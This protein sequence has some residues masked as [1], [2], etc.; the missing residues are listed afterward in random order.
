MS[1]TKINKK[2]KET[3]K[4][5]SLRTDKNNI[6]ISIVNNTQKA[7]RSGGAAN[8][9]KGADKRFRD[10][11]DPRPLIQQ[12]FNGF[13]GVPQTITNEEPSEMRRFT[14]NQGIRANLREA[15][16]PSSGQFI[17]G[18]QTV[19]TGTQTRGAFLQRTGTQTRRRPSRISFTNLPPLRQ[20]I[21]TQTDDRQFIPQPS[22][23]SV[24]YAAALLNEE[25]DRRERERMAAQA[26]FANLLAGVPPR[27]ETAARPFRDTYGPSGFRAT[28]PENIQ[29]L[30]DTPNET[31]EDVNEEPLL[32]VRGDAPFE[33][34]EIEED[35][36]QSYAAAEPVVEEQETEQEEA[37]A[38]ATA[39]PE[40]PKPARAKTARTYE[41]GDN[42]ALTKINDILYNDRLTIEKKL[43]Q[44][45]TKLTEHK[46]HMIE[47]LK[48][49]KDDVLKFN[50][51]AEQQIKLWM[52]QGNNLSDIIEL[53]KKQK[54]QN[55][56]VQQ[57]I[58][59]YFPRTKEATSGDV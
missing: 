36:T 38:V 19:D 40:K 9:K 5:A 7:R 3:G 45:N 58:T 30:E 47:R 12:F 26:E 33:E 39:E 21:D 22:R 23:E 52:E 6:T 59:E 8:D 24:T 18:M 37:L 55:K 42:S 43:K 46:T 10:T 50:E 16:L 56:N 29:P 14:E 4:S 27:F 2:R 28:A 31:L 57:L 53:R 11:R 1:E 44:V 13:G 51:M 20:S 34:P 17:T 25:N 54:K 41:K 48:R 15:E 35:E 32:M 49:G